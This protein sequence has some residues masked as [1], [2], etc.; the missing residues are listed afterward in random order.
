MEAL[1]ILHVAS[2]TGNIG[3]NA[4]HS[5]FKYRL[6]EKLG[7]PLFFTEYEIREIYWDN[8]RFDEGFVELANQ[9]DLV[10]VGGGNYFELWVDDSKTGCSFDIDLEL[11]KAINPPIVFNALGVDPAQG[12]SDE[13]LGKFRDFLDVIV[14]SPKMLLSCRNDGSRKALK[15][16]VGEEYEKV[17]FHVPDAGFYT[18]IS[19][20]YHPELD[21]TRKNII[22]QLAGDMLDSRFPNISTDDISFETF[23]DGMA[24]VITALC[25]GGG[26]V[27][28]VPHI[29]RDISII[30]AVIEKIPDQIRRKYVKTAPYLVG[31]EGQ[32]YIFD[33][34]SKSDLVLAMRF[35][36]NVCSLGLG[37]PC[38]GLVNYRQIRELFNELKASEYSVEVNKAGFEKQ[39]MSLAANAIEQGHEKDILDR[40]YWDKKYDHYLDA[41][42]HTVANYCVDFE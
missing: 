24:D 16:I 27:I 39:L 8:K 11:L 30:S 7:V 15:E 13:A 29:F 23:L 10:V 6:E 28:L 26:N 3:D 42:R 17:F 2:F 34:Y 1:H 20:H 9:Y 32:R 5:G 14:E 21:K 36:A 22:V 33:L 19:D 38:I 18:K 41:I 25:E 31:D 37:V 40:L 4:N 12:A 35:H